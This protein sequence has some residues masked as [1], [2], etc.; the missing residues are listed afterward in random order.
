MKP[1]VGRWNLFSFL[2]IDS[3]FFFWSRN[4]DGKGGSKNCLSGQFSGWGV[5]GRV[6]SIGEWG[7]NSHSLELYSIVHQLTPLLPCHIHVVESTSFLLYS[8]YKKKFNSGTLLPRTDSFHLTSYHYLP[9]TNILNFGIFIITMFYNVSADV[10]SD[11][12]QVLVYPSNLQGT[13]N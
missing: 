5:D 12:H 7:S 6:N 8:K 3:F 13:S 9:G 2:M 1:T 10:V 11:L 4:R